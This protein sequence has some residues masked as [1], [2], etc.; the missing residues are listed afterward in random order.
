MTR[1]YTYVYNKLDETFK[2][3]NFKTENDFI[4]Y[5]QN[6]FYAN[7]NVEF[8]N[9]RASGDLH[10]FDA[11]FTDRNNANNQARSKT[12]IIQLKEGTDYRLSFNVQ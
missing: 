10:I 8:S 4:A 5:M 6:A 9:Y 2:Q 7:N 12:F 11:T 1:D 3:N